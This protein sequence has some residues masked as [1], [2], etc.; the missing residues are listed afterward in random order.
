[1]GAKVEHKN[2]VPEAVKT[3]LPEAAVKADLPEVVDGAVEGGVEHGR[4][5]P[6]LLLMVRASIAELHGRLI[7]TF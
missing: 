5:G 1:M 4:Q 7:S 3:D 6:M 2:K